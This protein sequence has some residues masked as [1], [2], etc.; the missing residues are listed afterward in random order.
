MATGSVIAGRG[1]ASVGWITNG[2]SPMLNVIVS[3]PGEAFAAAIASAS[4]PGPL[5]A[6]VVTTKGGAAEVGT[7]LQAENSDVSSCSDW[8]LAVAVIHEP[9]AATPAAGA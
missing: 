8:S 7:C 1:F 5:A 4:E 9:G 3:V 2:G 6:V